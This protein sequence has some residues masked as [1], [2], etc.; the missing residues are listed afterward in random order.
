VTEGVVANAMH[1][2]A[3]T[4]AL[5][6]VCGFENACIDEVPHHGMTD[7]LI[8]LK[9]QVTRPPSLCLCLSLALSHEHTHTHTPNTHKHKILGVDQR[10][11]S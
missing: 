7:P 11:L 5:K 6:T 9:I 8:L 10:P 1:R 3:F 4:H 2:N